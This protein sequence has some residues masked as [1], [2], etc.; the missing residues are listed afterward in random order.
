MLDEE[1]IEYILDYSNPKEESSCHKTSCPFAV[2]ELSEQ[3]QNYGCLPTP[4]EIIRMRIKSNKT[5]ACHSNDRKP[6][7]GALQYL[8]AKGLPYNVVDR[9]L[10]T[11]KVDYRPFL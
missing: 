8:K 7:L 4:R 2:T 1:L 11:E 3:V 5:W 10:V 6:C 9:E